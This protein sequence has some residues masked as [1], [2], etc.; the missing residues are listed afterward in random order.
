MNLIDQVSPDSPHFARRAAVSILAAAV[1]LAVLPAAASATTVRYSVDEGGSDTF[2]GVA[3]SSGES[4]AITVTGAGGDLR[5]TDERNDIREATTQTRN[6]CERRS[7]R[8]IDCPTPGPGT[9]SIDGNDENDVLT[10][11]LRSVPARDTRRV[12]VDAGSGSDR[13]LIQAAASPGRSISVDIGDGTADQLSCSRGSGVRVSDRD[14]EDRVDEDCRVGPG[15]GRTPPAG[16]LPPSP[17]PPSD[18]TRVAGIECGVF[19]QNFVRDNTVGRCAT[20][21]AQGLVT[22]RV[23]ALTVCVQARFSGRQPRG[24]RRSDLGACEL[25]VSRTRA[26]F[27]FAGGSPAPPAEAAGLAAIEC[28]VFRQNFVRDNTTGRCV[29]AGAQGLLGPSVPALTVCVQA[30]FSGR[31][32]RGFARSDLEACELAVTRTR[33]RYFFGFL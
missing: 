2:L 30:R 9:F 4:N 32:P 10:V 29:A 8:Q 21:G 18:A 27:F 28:G 11:D 19:N 25:A 7:N 12:F 22:P 1:L 3:G 16:G 33:S 24:F 17:P 23:P 15:D 6:E 13:V 26:R 5:F 14:T 31:Q 20:A